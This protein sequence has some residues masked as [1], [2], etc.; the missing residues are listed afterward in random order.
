MLFYLTLRDGFT[1]LN[2]SHLRGSALR[3]ERARIEAIAPDSRRAEDWLS[4]AEVALTLDGRQL[5]K[6]ALA[7]ARRTPLNASQRARADL[8]EGLI[9]GAE[10]RW[11]DAAALLARAERGI[12]PKRRVTV[13]YGR[14]VA[15]SLADPKRVLPEPRV[16]VNSADA[17]LAHAFIAGFRQDLNAAAELAKGAEKRFP[18]DVGIAIFSSQ[19]SLALNRRDEMRASVE[20]AQAVDPHHHL[21]LAMSGRIKADVD[22]QRMAALADL[23]RA[24][25]TAPGDSEIWNAIG[26]LQSALDAPLEAEAAFRRSIEVDPDNPV[27]HAN[28]A[29]HLLDQSRVEEAGALIDKA[30]EIDP[31]FHVAYIARGRYLLQKGDTVRAIESIL[32]G[33]TA[34]PAY[35]NGLLLAAIAYYQNGE[36]DLAEQAFDNADRL[37]PNDP[38]VSTIRTAIALDQYRADDAIRFARESVKRSRARGGD[39]AGLSA[40]QQ[41]GSYPAA[42]YRF[43][44]LNEWGRFYGDRTFDPFSAASYFDQSANV[45]LNV[46]TGK[47]SLSSVETGADSDVAASNLV[48]Q[49]LLFDPL[50][51]GGRIGRIDVVRRPFLDME[52]GGGVISQNGELGWQSEISMSGFSNLPIPTSFSLNAGRKRLND[53]NSLI[54]EGA[55]SASLFVGMAPS[56]SDRFLVFGSVAD[57]NPGFAS[58]TPPSEALDKRDTV[59]IQAGGGWSHT[60]GHRNVLTSGLFY[61]LSNDRQTQFRAS[62]GFAQLDPAAYGFPVSA[63]IDYDFFAEGTIRRRTRVEGAVASLGHTYG[64]GDLTLRYGLEGQT[65]RTRTSIDSFSFAAFIDRNPFNLG[66]ADFTSA[67]STILEQEGTFN[68]GRAYVDA[69]W[70]PSDRFELQAGG[71]YAF[72]DIGGTTTTKIRSD[73]DFFN[74]ARRFGLSIDRISSDSSELDSAKFDPRLGAAFSPFEGQW[75]RAAYRYDTQLPLGTTLSPLSTVGL[76]P[77][78]LPTTTGSRIETAALRWDAEWSSQFFTAVEY[79][80][81][82]VRGLDLPIGSSSESIA[83]ERARIDRLAATANLWLG[84]GIGVFATVGIA[85]SENLTDGTNRGQA[86]PFIAE[87]FARF[88]ATFVHPSRLKLTVAQNF[89]G[90]RT[91]T[92]G[93]RPLEDFWTTDAAL[94]WETPDRRL[95]IGL[96]ALNLFDNDYE[97]AQTIAGPGRTVAAS[98]KARF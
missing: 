34:N 92:L 86:V 21:V 84:Y 76:I 67:D 53:R 68:A 71:Q 33:S 63:A 94:T 6:T 55:D 24:A 26:S 58:L 52:A 3:A 78:P 96:T 5:A 13:A 79:Q 93:G 11:G 15:A 75:L 61:T 18:N 49:G 12:D 72:Y 59:A 95:M 57:T 69:M 73:S 50:A 41:T 29:I 20:R 65:G 64:I 81:Q 1:W 82:E 38:S 77:N 87:R 39:F 35:S 8:V 40:N 37:D 91:G 51:V 30:L 16:D 2:P 25:A 17:A 97:L 90:D 56:A 36:F 88:G 62:E 47:P 28:L 7:E 74:T 46:V 19:L 43:I 9:T 23:Q 54:A 89:I 98:I 4:R 80:R 10:R 83:L 22:S 44:G 31:D 14:Y 60:F 45:R 48:V 32:A 42:A 85:D 27:P 70:R 66:L